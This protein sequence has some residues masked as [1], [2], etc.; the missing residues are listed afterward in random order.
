MREAPEAVCIAAE[1][2]EMGGVA[3]R[4]QVEMGP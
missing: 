2:E 3:A 4:A 1:Q